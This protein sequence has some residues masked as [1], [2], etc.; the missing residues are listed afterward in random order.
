MTVTV[1]REAY[2]D[3]ATATANTPNRQT[4][5]AVGSDGRQFWVRLYSHDLSQQASTGIRH[6]RPRHLGAAP[7][8]IDGAQGVAALRVVQ[9]LPVGPDEDASPVLMPRRRLR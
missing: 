1:A 7:A 8:D 5:P 3:V 6:R 9:S 4:T 2:G